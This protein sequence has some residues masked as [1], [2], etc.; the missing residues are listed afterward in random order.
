[1]TS[2]RALD[3][4]FAG[5]ALGVLG[6]VLAVAAGAVAIDDGAPILFRQSR[7]GRD[8]VQFEIMK[9]RTMRDG[10]VTRVGRWLRATGLD[11]LPQF[12]N[13]VRGE[14]S[15]VG[16]RPLTEADVA[17]LGLGQERFRV[18]PGITG[19][20]QLYG[21][22]GAR[23]S[24]RLDRLQIARKSARLDL[25]IVAASFAV[26]VAGKKRTKAWLASLRRA[27]RSLDRA[28]HPAAAPA[29][30]VVGTPIG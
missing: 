14:M 15:V 20:A 13:V 9:L 27:V 21:G 23:H 29:W 10:K 12:L 3:L 22:R 1:M 5:A 26:N 28:V 19:L 18:K 24:R 8:R 30:P 6:P 17:R 7:L 16:P 11:E 25:Q 4:L 2:E